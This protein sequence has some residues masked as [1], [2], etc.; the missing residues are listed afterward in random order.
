MAKPV[1][2][3]VT[4]DEAFHHELWGWYRKNRVVIRANYPGVTQRFLEYNA[5]LGYDEVLEARRARPRFLR[6]PQA[7]ALEMYIFLKERMVE[8]SAGGR[9]VRAW[10]VHEIFEKW[11]RKETPFATR[12]AIGL[13][14]DEQASLFDA[15][16]GEEAY[17]A[18]FEKMKKLGGAVEYANYIF[19][20]TMGTGKTLLMATCIFYDFLMANTYPKDVRYAH[21]ALIFAPDKTVL[22]TLRRD[23]EQFDRLLVV[24]PEYMHVIDAA[25]ARFLEED[26]ATLTGLRQRFNI[27]V[28]NAQKIIL[29]R[30]SKTPSATAKLFAATPRTLEPTSA[31]ARARN[32][33]DTEEIENEAE[34]VT[35]QRYET[36]RRMEQLGV[37]IDEAHHAFGNT[38]IKDLDPESATSLRRTVDLLGQ[39]LKER[40]TRVVGCYNFTGT[41][42]AK[43]QVFPEVVYAYGLKQ[44]I[45]AGYLKEVEV[46]HVDEKKVLEKKFVKDAVADFIRHHGGGRRYEGMLPKLAIFVPKI[47]D[48]DPV[49][50]VLLEVLGDAGIS[51]TSV[52][53]N[54]GDSKHTTADDIRS[55]NLLDTHD[56]DKQ[57]ILLVGKGKEGWNCRSLFGV[58]LY[59]KPTSKIFVLQASMRCLRAIDMPP[60]RTGRVYLSTQCKEM[61]DQELHENYKLTVD[62]LKKDGQSKQRVEVR[63]VRPVPHLEIRR[64]RHLWELKDIA[65]PR[66]LDLSFSE[67]LVERYKVLRTIQT[68]LRGDGRDVSSRSEVVDMEDR[69]HSRLTVVAEVA[70]YLNKS[71]IAIEELFEQTPKLLDQIVE[72]VS[73]H[74]DLLYDHVIP[75]VF[76]ALYQLDAWEKESHSSASRPGPLRMTATSCTRSRR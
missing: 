51:G 9:A 4:L 23:I 10:P 21:N 54:V 29:K 76:R 69:Q 7:Q 40:G 28:S 75:A 71:P 30:Q 15:D 49:R 66:P 74:N 55:F 39:D 44:A 60:T 5:P 19:A 14:V 46:Q 31:E 22:A 57:F 45:E 62:E 6:V 61:L 16:F 53:V 27:I 11:Y 65:S 32:L 72:W 47:K 3:V 58:V 18:A 35:N 63:P 20:L 50:R 70:R 73:R 38:L 8:R 56:S 43:G 12:D 13:S 17:K 52:L 42:Y 26:G 33:F 34:I 67:E 1:R 25:E 2:K 59:R 68:G 24:P 37:F 41:P 36:L 48:I 64:K